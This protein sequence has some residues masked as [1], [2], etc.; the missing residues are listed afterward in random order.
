MYRPYKY[1]C[2]QFTGIYDCIGTPIY[3]GDVLESNYNG[4]GLNSQRAPV[5][6]EIFLDNNH[7]IRSTASGYRDS[8]EFVESIVGTWITMFAYHV[9]GN[10]FFNPNLKIIKGYNEL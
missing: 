3:V 9:I 5:R 4:N 6:Q 7:K 1:D 8:F 2:R 10:V